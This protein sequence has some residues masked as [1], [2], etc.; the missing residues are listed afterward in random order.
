MRVF[1]AALGA[2]FALLAGTSA[3]AGAQPP[4]PAQAALTKSLQQGLALVGNQNGAYVLDLTTGQVLYS[5]AA[6]T[7]RLPASVE[8]VYTTSTALLRLGPTAT[9]TT[10]VLGT[11]SRDPEGVW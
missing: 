6:T 5:Q 8:K 3:V 10:S 1:L 9:F 2:T 11:G 4:S 7:A